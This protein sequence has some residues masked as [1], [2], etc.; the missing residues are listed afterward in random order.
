[1]H[2][3]CW[4][5]RSEQRVHGRRSFH[6]REQRRVAESALMWVLGTFTGALCHARPKPCAERR[7]GAVTRPAARRSRPWRGPARLGIVCAHASEVALV[8]PE[9]LAVVGSDALAHDV[10]HAH[11]VGD[12]DASDRSRGCHWLST[13]ARADASAAARA[14]ERARGRPAARLG[15]AHAREHL[16][17]D[18]GEVAALLC[19]SERGHECEL[20][21]GALAHELGGADTGALG[22]GVEG[23]P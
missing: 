14:G 4:F 9:R 23:R 7:L 10:D 3:R 1:M 21:F 22:L 6:A 5:A 12:R 18:A 13:Q 2:E 15:L 16:A 11:A 17:E 20:Q 8:T 19:G